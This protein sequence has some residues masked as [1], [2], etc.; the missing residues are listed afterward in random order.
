MLSVCSAVI[1]PW[2][3]ANGYVSSLLEPV[4]LLFSHDRMIFPIRLVRL[5]M[6]Y[7]CEGYHWNFLIT[8]LIPP[9]YTFVIGV[10]ALRHKLLQNY[11]M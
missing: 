11:M 4:K 9:K 3:L 7:A 2:V 6:E 5:V 8:N 1:H 10:I